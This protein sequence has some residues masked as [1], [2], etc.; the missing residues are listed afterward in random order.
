VDYFGLVSWDFSP[1]PGYY[2]YRDIARQWR[3]THPGDSSKEAG[4]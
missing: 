1:K 2:A 3:E 4:K